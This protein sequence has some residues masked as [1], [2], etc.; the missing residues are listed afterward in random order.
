MSETTTYLPGLSV[1]RYLAEVQA[2]HPRLR[3]LLDPERFGSGATMNRLCALTNEFDSDDSGR[4]GTYRRAHRD[5]LVR[6]TGAQQ[7]LRLAAP[8]DRGPEVLVLDVLGGDGLLAR[9]AHLRPE[10]LPDGLTVLTGDISGPMVAAALAHGLPAVRQAADQLLLA[11]RTVDAVL[12]AYGTHHIPVEERPLAVA[13]AVRVVRPGGRVVLHDFD[14]ASPMAVF[15]G[16]VVDRHGA[17][18]HDYP[19]F[20]RDRLWDL[21]ADHPVQTR[22]LDLYDPVTLR[23]PSPDLA[24]A[25]AVAYFADSYGLAAHFAALGTDGAW[26]LLCESFDHSDYPQLPEGR[27]SRPTVRPAEGGWAAEV[28]RVALVAVAE[29]PRP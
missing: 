20:S 23:A 13:E 28:P 8:A 15:F 26:D 17:V 10:Q 24:R 5:P 4:G 25:A 9:V 29:T 2:R 1:E 21:F 27:P 6:W 7:L 12:L 16:T 19:H 3:E 11:D 22:L 14:P 18:P